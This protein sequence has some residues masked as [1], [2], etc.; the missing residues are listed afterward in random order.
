MDGAWIMQPI[1]SLDS[2]GNI[3]FPCTTGVKLSMNSNAYFDIEATN[4]G[5]AI[6]FATAGSVNGQANSPLKQKNVHRNSPVER[7][8]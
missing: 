1:M 3:N 2:N 4:A 7:S 5:G 6:R 8:S